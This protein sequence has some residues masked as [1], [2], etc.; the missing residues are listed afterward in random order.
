MQCGCTLLHYA[1]EH[2]FSDVI[3]LLLAN[4]AN[5]SAVDEVYN[6][7]CILISVVNSG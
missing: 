4:N 3:D 6:I 7:V 1:A 5:A 2:G